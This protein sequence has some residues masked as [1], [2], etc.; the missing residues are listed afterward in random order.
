MKPS[1]KKKKIL[2]IGSGPYSIGSS[3]E[4]DW[5]GVQVLRTLRELGHET[6]FI[7]SNP[8]TVSTDYDECDRLYFEELTPERV[9]DICDREKPDGVIFSTGG[10]IAQNMVEELKSSG[11]PLLGTS[12]QSIQQCEDREKFSALCDELEIDQP[13][14]KAF[15]KGKDAIAFAKKE[16]FPVLVR[17]SFVLSGAAMAVA[18]NKEDLISYLDAAVG[19]SRASVVISKFEENAKEI[20]CD[21]VAQDGQIICSA[22][23]EHVENAGVHSGDA[24]IV[25]PAQD[26]RLE[27]IRRVRQIA[28]KLARKLNIS[29]PFNIQFLARENEIKVIECNLRASR[30]FPFASKVLGQN[31]IEIAT[32]IWM[33]EKLKPQEMNP[34]EIRS[35]GVKAAQFSFSR[36]KGADPVLGVEMSSTGEVACFG[37]TVEEAFLKSMLSV[38]FVL[39][40]P[41]SKIL[42]TIGKLKD[43]VK[44]LPIARRLADLGFSFVATAGTAD[45]LSENK[46]CCAKVYKISSGRHPNVADTIEKKKVA[47]VINTPNKFSHEE[48]SDGYLIRRKAVDRNVPLIANLQLAKLLARSLAKF[49]QAEDLP[50]FDY[51]GR[52]GRME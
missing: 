11:V 48:I 44:F 13:R 31:F 33:G 19:T 7:N 41:K 37:D 35:V 39:P 22:I 25:L 42:L 17:P 15:D 21:A 28:Q 6:L 3:V 36:L 26:L 45:F 23:A 10:Q 40:P 9:L 27:T 16:G 4:F 51:E 8:E 2:I 12:V 32:R 20:E 24:T 18:T 38:G 46:I 50:V 14:W 43:K 49:P 1:K 34:L 47:L 30:S 5:C 52:L 29:G